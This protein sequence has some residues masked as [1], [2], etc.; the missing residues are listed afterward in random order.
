MEVKNAE[1][2]DIGKKTWQR[3]GMASMCWIHVFSGQFHLKV[4]CTS[5]NQYGYFSFCISAIL[6]YDKQEVD[7]AEVNLSMVY[8]KLFCCEK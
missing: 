6:F 5:Q 8:L 1:E 3:C 7:N 4:T 2:F